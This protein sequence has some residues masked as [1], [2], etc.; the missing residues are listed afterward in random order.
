MFTIIF[1][2]SK[3]T[4]TI[5]KYS[6]NYKTLNQKIAQRM[7]KISPLRSILA[8]ATRVQR[9]KL[10]KRM[11]NGNEPN[12]PSGGLVDGTKKLFNPNVMSIGAAIGMSG[13]SMVGMVQAISTPN[14]TTE[15]RSDMFIKNSFDM[16]ANI[17]MFAGGP[18]GIAVGSAWMVTNTFFDA[19]EG[20]KRPAQVDPEILFKQ[21]VDYIQQVLPSADQMFMEM[22][23]Y[24]SELASNLIDNKM[25]KQ[26]QDSTQSSLRVIAEYL[27]IYDGETDGQRILSNWQSLVTATA[28]EMIKNKL[29]LSVDDSLDS[30][31]VYEIGIAVAIYP[32]Y[33][34]MLLLALKE[35]YL[36]AKQLNQ[37]TS[38][39][40]SKYND[41]IAAFRKQYELMVNKWYDDSQKYIQQSHFERSDS[42]TCIVTMKY[43]GLSLSDGYIQQT[44][45]ESRYDFKKETAMPVD[46]VNDK[47]C[48]TA[49]CKYVKML[50]TPKA[51]RICTFERTYKE[52]C[53]K[54]C[55]ATKRVF[56]IMIPLFGLA[57]TKC[58]KN[59]KRCT[60]TQTGLT[61]K[62]ETC[63][64]SNCT[65]QFDISKSRL[66]AKLEELVQLARQTVIRYNFL[67]MNS[68]INNE[69]SF[70]DG[71]EQIKS[72]S[73]QELI[74]KDEVFNGKPCYG[75]LAIP[76]VHG[77][78]KMCVVSVKTSNSCPT[79]VKGQS[80]YILYPDVIRSQLPI[81]CPNYIKSV[82][83]IFTK[84]Q[85]QAG[86]KDPIT[87][88]QFMVMKAAHEKKRNIDNPNGLITR[89]LRTDIVG[90]INS[91]T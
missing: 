11:I 46:N 19:F 21:I 23:G 36:T 55:S 90:D 78:P 52:N 3:Y 82:S 34:S 81:L 44:D 56:S 53:Q 76:K 1:A 15:D 66:L 87:D 33:V 77:V 7:Y 6:I 88:H 43:P 27:A 39:I 18:F 89:S 4:M 65:Q 86:S 32:Q 64:P 16:T 50:E 45:A 2:L 42:S 91:A 59:K 13:P 40:R 80:Q 58:F 63:K 85:L 10:V 48:R 68:T 12:Q 73:L 29:P 8:S 62:E 79:N 24:I 57:N 71:L 72:L 67:L 5:P 49:D 70:I 75:K 22:K 54:P 35:W 30:F 14:M 38:P 47:E 74:P 41:Y 28:R 60:Y 17:L 84:D 51:E 83:D 69:G 20:P 37:P 25:Q 26:Y 31:E 61:I 9:T